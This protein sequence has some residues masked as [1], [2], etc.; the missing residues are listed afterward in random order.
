MN[1]STPSASENPWEPVRRA[2]LIVRPALVGILLVAGLTAVLALNLQPAPQFELQ[3]GDAAPEDILAPRIITYKSEVL[4]EIARQAAAA[5]VND[6]YNPPDMRISRAQVNRARLILDFIETVG[7]DTLAGR[8]R[9]RKYI[10][11][12]PELELSSEMIDM[13]LGLTANKWETVREMTLDVL[14]EAMRQQ[15]DR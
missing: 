10:N 11:S 13:L 7:A 12:V 5:N 2:W 4:T 1:T 6:V 14:D 15:V 8:S 3:V 9:Q